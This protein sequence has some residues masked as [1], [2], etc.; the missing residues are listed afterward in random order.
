LI[1]AIHPALET[2]VIYELIQAKKRRADRS[3]F[4]PAFQGKRGHPTLIAWKHVPETGIFPVDALLVPAHAKSPEEL[5]EVPVDSEAILLKIDTPY[6]YQKMRKRFDWPPQW[7]LAALAFLTAAVPTLLGLYVGASAEELMF[8]G[9]GGFVV[10]VVGTYKAW[11]L[12]DPTQNPLVNIVTGTLA[13]AAFGALI[14]TLA[15]RATQ[16]LGSGSGALIVGVVFGLV[17]FCFV[18]LVVAAQKIGLRAYR[19]GAHRQD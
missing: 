17:G 14:G 4:I 5:L 13:S 2:L 18:S 6:G 1:L 12:I 8:L 19:K 10:G 9:I 3:I 15:G 16:E 11:S 7:V